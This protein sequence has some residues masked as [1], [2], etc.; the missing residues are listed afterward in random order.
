M[1]FG[2]SPGRK[3]RRE[4]T[5][6]ATHPRDGILIGIHPPGRPDR[7]WHMWIKPADLDAFVRVEAKAKP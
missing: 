7:G 5:V 6:I 2:R 4:L 3:H 1:A